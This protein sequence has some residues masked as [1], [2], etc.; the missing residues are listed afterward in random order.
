MIKEESRS[1]QIRS[2]MGIG[3]RYCTYTVVSTTVASYS[4]IV[5]SFRFV[6]C[7]ISLLQRGYSFYNGLLIICLFVL[8]WMM[9][10]PQCIIKSIRNSSLIIIRTSS[11][12]KQNYYYPKMRKKIL[13]CK[14]RWGI[15]LYARSAFM[16][17]Q[18]FLNQS[19]LSCTIFSWRI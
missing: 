7:L 12:V 2:K 16:Q 5:V 4:Y 15:F 17:Q 14:W 18:F 3:I 13:M 6:S 19:L 10:V 11:V 9:H 8:D 1:D